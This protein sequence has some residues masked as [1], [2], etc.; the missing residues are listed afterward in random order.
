MTHLS[1]KLATMRLRLLQS[2]SR[3]VCNFFSF[4]LITNQN[5]MKTQQ[6]T[7]SEVSLIYRSKVKASDRPQV[8]CSRDAYKLSIESWH[9]G[10]IE[11]VE[12]FKILL[13]N[14][15]DSVLGILDISKG[16]IS[17]TVTDVRLIFQAADIQL[18]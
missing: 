6:T 1:D 5:H 14:R 3:I 7:M 9:G 10:I 8:K 15:S 16:G 4:L 12:E 18:L 11:F 17:G 13:L 2:T